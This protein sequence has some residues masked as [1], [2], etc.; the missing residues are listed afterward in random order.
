MRGLASLDR[1]MS[2]GW[3]APPRRPTARILA[4]PATRDSS[5]LRLRP[6]SHHLHPEFVDLTTSRLVE[7]ALRV[8]SV[9]WFRAAARL[10][11]STASVP[12]HRNW[13][14][15]AETI[16]APKL[17]HAALRALCDRL[18]SAYNQPKR[19]HSGRH[20]A[21][22]ARDRTGPR[23]HR[24]VALLIVHS[25]RSFL[26]NSVSSSFLSAGASSPNDSRFAR[27]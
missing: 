1:A 22:T 12:N 26:H 9:A 20:Q 7:S 17:R 27:V 4:N 11:N 23:A 13:H 8:S 19:N 10:G 14:W 25:G 5:V 6:R 24:R 18:T 3:R 16:D 2:A 21:A 15:A